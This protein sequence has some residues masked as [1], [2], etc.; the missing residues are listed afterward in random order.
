MKAI[1]I[2]ATSCAAMAALLLAAAARTQVSG[3]G[4]ANRLEGTWR[5]QGTLVN[6]QTGAAI[7]TFLG[8]NS[9][10]PGG[11]M[12]A[13]GASNPALTSTGYGVWEHTEGGNFTNTIVMFRFNGDGS[14]AGT[15]KVTRMIEVD[16]SADS[17]TSTNSVEI[18]DAT[19]N[20]TATSCSTES[21]HRLE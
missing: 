13:T 8:M 12:L 5:T 4:K 11:G 2:R 16:S 20:V 9:F 17:F 15:Q 7:R 21:A 1:A 14:F 18:A 6:C 3:N 10:L 19:G